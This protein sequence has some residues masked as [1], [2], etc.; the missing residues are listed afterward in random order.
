MTDSH[1]ECLVPQSFVVPPTHVPLS[2]VSPTV[3]NLPSSHAVPLGAGTTTQV[4]ICPS[5]CPV[6]QTATVHCGVSIFEQSTPHGE[7]S[8]PPAPLLLAL[9]LLALVEL[10][11]VSGR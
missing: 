2:Q 6:L 5:S 11:P 3:Q 4:L 1:D 7:G 10:S 8:P 9:A